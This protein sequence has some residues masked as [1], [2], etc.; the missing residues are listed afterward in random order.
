M[1]PQAARDYPLPTISVL[2]ARPP[3]HN[4]SSVATGEKNGPKYAGNIE[5]SNRGYGTV[6]PHLPYCGRGWRRRRSWIQAALAFSDSILAG[7][8]SSAIRSSSSCDSPGSARPIARPSCPFLRC[9]SSLRSTYMYCSH[10]SWYVLCD[11]SSIC[12]L[13]SV[14]DQPST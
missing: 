10:S 13:L 3:S 12:F 5:P 6:S 14:F 11:S 1:T 8:S 2:I 9:S 4:E 7:R